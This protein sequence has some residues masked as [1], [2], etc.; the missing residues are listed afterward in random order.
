MALH[1]AAKASCSAKTVNEAFIREIKKTNTDV[2][3]ETEIFEI[4]KYGEKWKIFSKN[5]SL[6]ILTDF[7]SYIII[8]KIFRALIDARLRFR[9]NIIIGYSLAAI[10]IL[11]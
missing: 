10:R 9:R 6:F 4:E 1:A 2:F 11:G 3:C 7:Y 8:S 5:K